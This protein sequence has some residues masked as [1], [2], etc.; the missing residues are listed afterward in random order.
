MVRGVYVGE[1]IGI[2]RS[3]S[4]IFTVKTGKASIRKNLSVT[5]SY[6][7]KETIHEGKEHEQT[8]PMAVNLTYQNGDRGK[9]GV[10]ATGYAVYGLEDRTAV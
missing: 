2:L 8:F 4:P 6:M 10:K 1:L 5:A 9:S 7:T 3:A